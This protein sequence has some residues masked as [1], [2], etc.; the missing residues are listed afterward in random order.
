M[1]R[2]PW[3]VVLGLFV[4]ACGSD[5]EPTVLDVAKGPVELEAAPARDPIVK[6]TAPSTVYVK[7]NNR[8]RFLAEWPHERAGEMSVPLRALDDGSGPM[9]IGLWVG[10][11][12]KFKGEDPW[13]QCPDCMAE[14]QAF[15]RCCLLHRKK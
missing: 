7:Q 8:M 4:V 14:F 2:L 6:L 12:S 10:P 5:G 13:L 1:K 11:P 9:T 3:L 15:D